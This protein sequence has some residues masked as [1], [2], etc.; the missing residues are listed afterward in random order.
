MAVVPF[1]SA[2]T[3]I[4]V[5]IVNV[6]TTVAKID[7]FQIQTAGKPSIDSTGLEDA[8][9]TTVTGLP[10]NG[11][12]SGTIHFDPRDNTHAYLFTRSQ[13]ANTEEMW[14]I[15]LPFSA[16]K[17]IVTFNGSIQNMQLT[18]EKDSTVKAPITIQLS[19]AITFT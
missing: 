18:L 1:S 17:N 12:A 11:Q 5:N 10:D 6:F 8:A 4:Q 19:G 14:K 3:I 9:K 16:A 2:G 15:I 7:G 13:A